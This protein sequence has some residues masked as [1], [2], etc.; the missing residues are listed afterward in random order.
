MDG[1]RNVFDNFN[2]RIFYSLFYLSWEER[3]QYCIRVYSHIGNVSDRPAN[4]KARAQ[5]LDFP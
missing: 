2:Y 1:V 3:G 4:R 5:Y